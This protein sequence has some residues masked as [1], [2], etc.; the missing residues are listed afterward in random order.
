MYVCNDDDTINTTTDNY[1]NDDIG[2]GIMTATTITIMTIL[3]II[4]MI[5]TMIT[6]TAIV[7]MKITQQ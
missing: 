3:M 2:N 6:K 4:V 7:M 1:D 5:I